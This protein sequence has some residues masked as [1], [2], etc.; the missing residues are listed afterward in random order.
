MKTFSRYDYMAE[1]KV[2]DEETGSYYPDPLTL[3]Y[4]ALNLTTV[5]LKDEM[6]NS[7][8]TDLLELDKLFVFGT[9]CFPGFR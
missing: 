1:S 2:V 3:N 7:K 8:I 5:P 4:L 6:T 9:F